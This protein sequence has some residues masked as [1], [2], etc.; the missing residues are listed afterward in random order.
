MNVCERNRTEVTRI[1]TAAIVETEQPNFASLDS[2]A[3][4]RDMRK[5]AARAVTLGDYAAL[6]AH[7]IDPDPS[8]FD[9]DDVDLSQQW[10]MVSRVTLAECLPPRWDHRE[11]SFRRQWS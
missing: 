9:F 10:G 6:E 2:M 11:N 5:R 4:P 8:G 3:A 7:A 1:P